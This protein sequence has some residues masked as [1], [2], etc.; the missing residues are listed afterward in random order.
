M[1]SLFNSRERCAI[2][3]IPSSFGMQDKNR[4]NMA[5][6]GNGERLLFTA[7]PVGPEA[8]LTMVCGSGVCAWR[9]TGCVALE[10]GAGAGHATGRL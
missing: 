4:G 3:S 6:M 1:P 9:N 2:L 10:W 5:R 8:A 7:F